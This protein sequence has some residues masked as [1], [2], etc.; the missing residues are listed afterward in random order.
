MHTHIGMME[1]GDTIRT[2]EKIRGVFLVLCGVG[3]VDPKLSES[4]R[5]A[6]TMGLSSLVR[7]PPLCCLEKLVTKQWAGFGLSVVS[8]IGKLCSSLGYE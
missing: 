2:V 8:M 3:I 6:I 7:N 4:V 1:E 5:G